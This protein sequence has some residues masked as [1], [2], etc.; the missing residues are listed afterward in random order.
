[1]NEEKVVQI[2]KNYLGLQFSD[3]FNNADIYCYQENTKDG[4]EVYVLTHDMNAPNIQEEVYYY[5]HELA[6]DLLDAI[7]DVGNEC[8]VY[9]D[10]YLLE[11]LYFDEKLCEFFQEELEEIYEDIKE[12]PTSYNISIADIN[13][14]EEQ[15]KEE[16]EEETVS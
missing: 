8:E 12:N 2:V 6:D 7:L 1:M 3:N 9:C 10:E 4:Y 13:W 11:D 14:I 5:D 15:L 16:E